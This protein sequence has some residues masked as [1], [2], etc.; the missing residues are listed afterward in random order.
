MGVQEA[1]LMEF[2]KVP[3]KNYSF[4]FSD[5]CANVLLDA[6]CSALIES[7]V[8]WGRCHQCGMVRN[9]AEA[10]DMCDA[11][12]QCEKTNGKDCHVQIL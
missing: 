2:Q 11:T 1:Y 3:V 12:L 10:C 9:C 6:D 8:Y 5:S 4:D 7:R